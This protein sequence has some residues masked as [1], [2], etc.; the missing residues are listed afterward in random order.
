MLLLVG[1]LFIF[2]GSEYSTSTIDWINAHSF[3][4]LSRVVDYGDLLA[5]ITLPYACS[6][7]QRI[8]IGQVK[9]RLKMIP[10]LSLL[11]A[12]VAFLATSKDE[13]FINCYDGS[14]YEI[15]LSEEELKLKMEDNFFTDASGF[16]PGSDF[17]FSEYRTAVCGDSLR[18]D[19]TVKLN[20]VTDSTSTFE[21]YNICFECDNFIEEEVILEDFEERV[22]NVLRGN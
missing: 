13:P 3:F 22:V 4:H 18:A 16:Q 2:W 6:C 17:T 9:F 14:I 5:L 11:L 19:A 7:L 21:V 12:S 15:S 1:C 20:F 10:A 8:V